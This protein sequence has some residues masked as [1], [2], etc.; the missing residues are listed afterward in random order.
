MRTLACPRRG[1]VV[2]QR[3][4]LQRLVGSVADGGYRIVGVRDEC[5]RFADGY[6]V[7]WKHDLDQ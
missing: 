4:Q 6:G 3:K 7:A 5:E 1:I 2:D